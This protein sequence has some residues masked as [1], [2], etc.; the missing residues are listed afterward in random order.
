M[1][2]FAQDE[3]GRD[4]DG[5]GTVIDSERPGS[6][7]IGVASLTGMKIF[8]AGGEHVGKISEIMLDVDRGRVAYAVMSCGGFLEMGQELYVIPWN[9]LALDVHKGCFRLNI[10]ANRVKSAPFFD[11]KHWPPMTNVKWGSSV[12]EYYNRR[13]YWQTA[14]DTFED[15]PRDL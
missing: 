1:S 8:A 5:D 9:A 14:V 6:S 11:S 12:H 4:I 15:D 7:V 2:Q 13:P 3:N 10:N